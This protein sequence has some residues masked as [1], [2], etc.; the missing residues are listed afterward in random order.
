M[1]FEDEARGS[2]TISLKVMLGSAF[3]LFAIV[4]F[5]II[6][7]RLY[8]RSRLRHQQRRRRELV[9]QISNQIAPVGVSSSESPKSGLD[10]VII[11]SLPK[12]L[13]KNSEQFSHGEFPECSVCLGTIVED[14]TVRVLPNC[15]HMFHVDCIDTWFGSNTTCPICRTVAEPVVQKG[16]QVQPTAPPVE[17]GVPIDANELEKVGGSG[18]PGLRAAS[19]QVMLSRGRPV[20]ESESVERH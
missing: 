13:Y 20:G 11:A 16:P 1:G 15:K 4:L 5:I 10:P 6:F 8:A 7:F 19:F 14:A 3:A 17:E 2:L 9:F 12:L 18:T